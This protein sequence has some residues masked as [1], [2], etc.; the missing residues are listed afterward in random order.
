ML[1]RTARRQLQ[2]EIGDLRNVCC[3]MRNEL[4]LYGQADH[5]RWNSVNRLSQDFDRLIAYLGLEFKDTE[6]TRVIRPKQEQP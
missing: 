1:S 3:L 2:I 6:A 5:N 4:L